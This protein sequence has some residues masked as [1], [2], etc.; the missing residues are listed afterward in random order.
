MIR[1]ARRADP[2]S[3]PT[4]SVSISRWASGKVMSGPSTWLALAEL[5]VESVL[6]FGISGAGNPTHRRPGCGS[7]HH[8]SDHEVSLGPGVPHFSRESRPERLFEGPEQGST[9]QLVLV[10]GDTVP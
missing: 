8:G 1:P 10:I 2:S 7:A 3:P 4:E 5:F 6:G 9:N